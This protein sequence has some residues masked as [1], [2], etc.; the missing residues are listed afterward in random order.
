M[1]NKLLTA[2]DIMFRPKIVHPRDPI[3]KLKRILKTTEDTIIVINKRGKFLGEIHEYDLLKLIVPEQ[4]ISEE[5]VVGILGMGYDRGF[6]AKDARDLMH[7]HDF[8]AAPDTPIPNLALIMYKE[9]IRAI[10]IIKN[11]KVVG[12]VHLRNLIKCIHKP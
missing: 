5:E 11:K 2:R 4:E 12:V 10:P 3:A 8:V 1:V 9:E 6:I 7:A